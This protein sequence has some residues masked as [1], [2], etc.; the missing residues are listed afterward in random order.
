VGG[1][2]WIGKMGRR[3]YGPLSGVIDVKSVSG[4]IAAE[5]SCESA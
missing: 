4:S 2:L 1:Y 5:N 3:N